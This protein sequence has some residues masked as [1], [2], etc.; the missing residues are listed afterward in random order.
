MKENTNYIWITTSF[1]GFHSYPDAP[2]EVAF[3][4]AAKRLHLPNRIKNSLYEDRTHC[5]KS[6]EKLMSKKNCEPVEIYHA[7]A[8]LSVE[9]VVF[10]MAFLLYKFFYLKFPVGNHPL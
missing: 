1:E 5:R 4:K 2:D 7:F 9:G 8:N 10:L 6:F 3:L